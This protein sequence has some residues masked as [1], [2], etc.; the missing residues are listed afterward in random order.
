ML[1][2]SQAYGTLTFARLL[3]ADAMQVTAPLGACPGLAWGAL[4]SGPH[5]NGD[6]PAVP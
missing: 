1:S 3:N 5:G 6:G 4:Y 2:G